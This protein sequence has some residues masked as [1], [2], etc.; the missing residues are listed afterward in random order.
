[1]ERVAGSLFLSSTDRALL[2]QKP[3][4]EI[5]VKKAI[6]TITAT[7]F[8]AAA[9]LTTTASATPLEKG[10]VPLPAIGLVPIMAALQMKEN[11][12]FKPVNPY[13]KRAKRHHRH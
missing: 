5:E 6:V 12:N 2:N 4:G 3:E 10:P 1:M 7:A 8:L 11:K 13:A 9:A